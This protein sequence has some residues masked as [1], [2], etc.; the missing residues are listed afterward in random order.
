MKIYKIIACITISLSSMT[1]ADLFSQNQNLITPHK[2]REIEQ[3]TNQQMMRLNQ[4]QNNNNLQ[5]INQQISF[6]E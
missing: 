5:L 6:I 1:Y 4:T 2:I 3:N